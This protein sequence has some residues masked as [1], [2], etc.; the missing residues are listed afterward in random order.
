VNAWTALVLIVAMICT[1]TIIF[2]LLGRP[3]R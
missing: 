2:G 3:R 1:T